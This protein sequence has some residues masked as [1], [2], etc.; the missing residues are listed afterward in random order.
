MNKYNLMPGD[1][2]LLNGSPIRIDWI[3][4]GN[5][6]Y[7]NGYECGIDDV[8]PIQLTKELM[9]CNGFECCEPFEDPLSCYY[10]YKGLFILVS[11][12]DFKSNGGFSGTWQTSDP[13]GRPCPRYG[14]YNCRYVHELQQLLRV[15]K[16]YDLAENFKLNTDNDETEH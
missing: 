3:F 13:Y 5:I 8:E 16:M 11:I 15:A 2:V 7:D 10:R 9:V 14:V 1:W 6:F 12:F 4:R